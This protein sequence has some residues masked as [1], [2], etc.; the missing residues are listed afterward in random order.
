MKLITNCY[1]CS[2][3]ELCHGL[4]S[5]LK[6]RSFLVAST[7]YIVILAGGCWGVYI[8][9][10]HIQWFMLWKPY[11]MVGPERPE[12]GG[13]C[14]VLKLRWTGTHRLQM[15]GVPPWL[16]RPWAR[17]AGTRDFILPWLLWSALNK[18]FF[19][20]HTLF[21]F[22]CPHRPATWAGSRAGPPVSKCVSP[23]G[24]LY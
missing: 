19:P 4:L 20:H 17:R 1:R 2:D 10:T 3:A 22:M 11:P 24:T 9:T 18:L 13:P 23:G 8:Y 5:H 16:V 15:E 14:W 21:Q 7:I 12:R 6:M